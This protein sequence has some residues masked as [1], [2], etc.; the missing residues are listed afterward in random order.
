MN[1]YIL[2][3]YK[4]TYKNKKKKSKKNL[5]QFQPIAKNHSFERLWYRV[6]IFFPNLL[7]FLINLLCKDI[8][9]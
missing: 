7:N 5:N 4:N 6:Y 2:Y 8:S 1:S 3:I 9:I